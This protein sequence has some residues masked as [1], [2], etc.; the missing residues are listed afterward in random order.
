[1]GMILETKIYGLEQMN[2]QIRIV[3]ELNIELYYRSCYRLILK[4]GAVG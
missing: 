1:M 4:H 2:E 3:V